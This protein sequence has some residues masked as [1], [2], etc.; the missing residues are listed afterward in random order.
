MASDQT[1]SHDSD[2]WLKWVGQDQCAD[3]RMFAFLY[4]LET[5]MKWI[6]ANGKIKIEGELRG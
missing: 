3:D 5:H 4:L 6:T 1:I 2:S